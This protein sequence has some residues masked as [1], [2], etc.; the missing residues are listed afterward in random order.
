MDELIVFAEVGKNAQQVAGECPEGWIVMDS[1]RPINDDSADYTAQSDGAWAISEETRLAKLAAQESI[2]R[3]GELI[4]IGRQL[5]A[6]EEA[7]VA[8]PGDE[9]VD[10]LPGTR[11]QW[12]KH[13]GLVSNWVEGATGYPQ[14]ASRPV[15]PS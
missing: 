14:E 6:I 2:W 10:L 8:D 11:K 13:R 15:R 4:V 9:P 5:E 12:L 3:A 1:Q 7:E